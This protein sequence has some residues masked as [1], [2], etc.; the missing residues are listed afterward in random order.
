MGK[1]FR[2]KPEFIFWLA[3]LVIFGVLV[4]YAVLTVGYLV[5][6]FNA[7]SD[8]NLLKTQEIVKFNL[9]KIQQLKER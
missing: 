3:A 5:R 7:I 8:P 9:G 6:Q 1:F 4:V 2:S